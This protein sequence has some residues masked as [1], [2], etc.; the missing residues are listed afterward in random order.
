MIFGEGI[1]EALL[2]SL[3]QCVNH[4]YVATAYC[5]MSAFEKVFIEQPLQS[6]IKILIVRWE[7]KDLLMG[8]SDIDIYPLAKKHGWKV[9]INNNLH[10]KVYCFDD[11]CFIGS[12]NL[13]NSGITGDNSELNLEVVSIEKLNSDIDMW[14]SEL[15]INSRL[16]DDELFNRIS[17]EVDN[18]Q[19]E[20]NTLDNLTYSDAVLSLLQPQ[21]VKNL[22][23]NDL[24][25]TVNPEFMLDS[26]NTTD[27][28]SKHDLQLLSLSY[29]FSHE[30]IAMAFN[31]SKGFRWLNRILLQK[32]EIYFGELSSLLHDSLLD[33]PA[34]YRKTVKILLN[35]LINWLECCS[36]DRFVIDSPNR[37]TRIRLRENT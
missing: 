2:L 24:V 13:T 16:I 29:E 8:A 20:K 17:N 14:F 36:S 19:H 31:Q 10:A 9:F 32:G 25:W 33:D 37:S 35:N 5:K 1:K 3:S 6:K 27:I 15:L 11:D 4:C 7:L 30:D 12:A 23:T 18:H 34:P 26:A 28:N 22:Y 21:T